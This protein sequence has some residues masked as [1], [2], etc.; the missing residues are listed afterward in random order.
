MYFVYVNPCMVHLVHDTLTS[1]GWGNQGKYPTPL[2]FVRRLNDVAS[3]DIM[4]K[5]LKDAVRDTITQA[6]NVSNSMSNT[7]TL[8]KH[9]IQRVL[10]RSLREQHNQVV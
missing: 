3:V 2:D 7:H 10:E 9:R 6:W 8:I 4:H 1:V 5:L